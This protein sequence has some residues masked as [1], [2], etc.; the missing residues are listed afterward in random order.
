MFCIVSHLLRPSS[1]SVQL[2]QLQQVFAELSLYPNA[3]WD[4]SGSE[5]LYSDRYSYSRR[6]RD[7]GRDSSVGDGSA[8]DSSRRTK[9]ENDDDED[10]ESDLRDACLTVMSAKRRLLAPHKDDTSLSS[11]FLSSLFPSASPTSPTSPT[12]STSTSTS[13][14]PTPSTFP[15]SPS[16]SDHLLST[17]DIPNV[18][19]FRHTRSSY[20]HLDASAI[21]TE[22]GYDENE[23]YSTYL[24]V[25]ILYLP[26]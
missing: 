2:N 20:T 15:A 17:L 9:D 14:S 22:M 5:R 1:S 11:P 19:A 8:R 21:L 7:R 4:A 16:V 23:I 26:S 3:K 10:E 6:E 24:A 18:R 25:Q 12:S 13:T